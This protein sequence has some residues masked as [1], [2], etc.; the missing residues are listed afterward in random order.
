[1]Q[2]GKGSGAIQR[3]AQQEALNLIAAVGAQQFKL[4]FGFDAFGN[5]FEAQRMGQGDGAE[6]DGAVVEV[7]FDV[8]NGVERIAITMRYM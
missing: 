2:E 8:G 1:M 4:V 7:G 6:S 3:F 5:D